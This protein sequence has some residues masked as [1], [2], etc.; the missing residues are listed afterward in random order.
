MVRVPRLRAFAVVLLVLLTV[1][2]FP[3]SSGASHS[4]GNYHFARSANPLQLA[5]GDNVTSNWDSY[6]ATASSDWS[7]SSVLNTTVVSGGTTGR[8]CRPTAGRVE[9]CNARYGNNG[10]LGLAQIWLSGG[11][12]A[13]GIAKMNDTYFDT[14]SYN[15]PAWRAH[16][17]CQEV[18]H[19]FGLDHQDESG[20]SLGTC[21]DYSR[22]PSGSQHPNAHDYEQLE[23]IYA[24]LDGAAPGGTVPAAASNAEVDT[25]AQWGRLLEVSPNGYNAVY[26]RD[27]GGGVVLFTFVTWAR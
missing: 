24:H 21:M 19:T 4:W 26:A 7:Q 2:A 5:L 10:W 1:A 9:V 18:G 3:L 23:I 25:P 6:L 11:H 20:A 27:F 22:D 15:T 16:V 14:P 17:M 12:I 13:Q 8:R